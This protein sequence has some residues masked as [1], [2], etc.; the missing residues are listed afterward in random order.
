MY[1]YYVYIYVFSEN[2]F[3]I[4]LSFGLVESEFLF[5]GKSTVLST[6]FFLLAETIISSKIRFH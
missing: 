3:L 2:V 4:N 6:A 1:I 5:S